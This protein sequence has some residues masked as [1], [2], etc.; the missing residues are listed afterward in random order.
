LKT[1]LIIP[2]LNEIDGVRAILPRIKPGW[3]DQIIIV[4]GN[5]TDGT[6]EYVKEQGYFVIPQEEKGLRR[7]YL[8][9]L[10][11]VEGDVIVTFSSDGISV[12]E[13]IP[14]LVAKMKEGYDMV[15]VSRYLDDARS[16]DDTFIT[17]LANKVFTLTTNLFFGGKYTDTMVIYRAYKKELIPALDLDKDSS[18]WLGERLIG[19]TMSWEMLLSIRAAKRKLK[20]A[21][22]PGDEPPRTDGIARMQW[23]WG[24]AYILQMFREVFFWR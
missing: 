20:V 15:I 5:S 14:P 18:Y 13:L 19:K 9:A 23:R 7:A 12:P 17:A 8:E 10:P 1:T 16:Y 22:I 11:Y 4:D 24:F 3:C 6:A 2:T 21:E